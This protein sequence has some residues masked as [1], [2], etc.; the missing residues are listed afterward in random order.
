MKQ[1]V[2]KYILFK[3]QGQW[4]SPLLANS[5]KLRAVR[6]L[7]SFWPPSFHCDRSIEIVLTRLRI[8]HCRLMHSFI[9][10]GGSGPVC[11]H[12]DNILTVEHVLVHC[13]RCVNECCY[14]V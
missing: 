12:C 11:A 13:T 8:G 10:D 6:S 3:W 9:L 2:H 5:R 4:L 1:P 14:T 7:L